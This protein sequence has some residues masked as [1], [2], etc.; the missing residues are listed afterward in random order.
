MGIEAGEFDIKPVSA[1]LT[2]G[3]QLAVDGGKVKKLS[4]CFTV[5]CQL[6]VDGIGPSYR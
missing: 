2:M 5:G 1:C 3:C 6:A 4:S